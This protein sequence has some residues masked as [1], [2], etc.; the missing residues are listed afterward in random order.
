MKGTR[1]DLAADW[2]VHSTFS[3]G[4]S[5]IGENLAQAHACGLR[6][7]CLVDHVR[8]DTAWVDDFADAVAAARRD[9]GPLALLCAVE[10]KLL[11]TRGALDMPR[12]LP[13]GVGVFAADHQVPTPDGPAHPREIARAV[14]AGQIDPGTVVSWITAATVG[15][16]AGNPGLRIAHLFSV[17]PK[18]GL[19]EDDVPRREVERI[20]A[21]AARHGAIVEVSERWRCP[22]PSVLA[23]LADARVR[24]VASTDSH[25]HET[26]GRYRYVPD[27]LRRAGIAA[28]CDP[29]VAT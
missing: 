11:D 25:A 1:V 23:I 12:Q 24:L 29:R 16:M 20:A 21:A 8:R 22:S 14:A 9:A 10:A 7:V 6:V 13:P 26:L 18:I 28:V 3:D 15:A 5:T 19:S 17:L 4:R 2:H 27:A